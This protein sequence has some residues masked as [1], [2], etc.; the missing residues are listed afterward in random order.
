MPRRRLKIRRCALVFLEVYEAAES[1]VKA[2]RLRRVPGLACEA[3][4]ASM[5]LAHSYSAL[6]PWLGAM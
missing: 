6:D 1:G 4:Y 3:G 5:A 2:A